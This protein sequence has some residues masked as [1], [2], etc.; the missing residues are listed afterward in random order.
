M[1]L[2]ANAILAADRPKRSR[3]S[4]FFPLILACTALALVVISTAALPVTL[5]APAAES[6]VV[7]P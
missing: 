5:K 6:A 7:G 4:I 2:A 1:S 3:A